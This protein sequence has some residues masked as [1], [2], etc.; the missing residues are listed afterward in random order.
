[1]FTNWPFNH[2]SSKGK[3]ISYYPS[4]IFN[5]EFDAN[6]VFEL[7]LDFPTIVAAYDEVKDVLSGEFFEGYQVSESGIGLQSFCP[8]WNGDMRWI[9]PGDEAGFAFFDKYFDKLRVAEKTNELF[10]VCNELIMY[11]GFFVVRSFTK[12][13]YYHIDYSGSVGLNAFT[14]MT[15]VMQTRV[16]NLLYHDIK[17]EEQVYNYTRGKAV[18]F[19]GDFY[20]STEPFE[21]PEPYVFLCFTYGVTDTEIWDSIAET[22]A[23]QCKIFRHP[24]QGIVYRDS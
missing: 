11:S 19:G 7:N 23:E 5:D 10:G 14:L 24:T 12:N 1:M 15:P 20:H 2:Y 6:N 3:T 21:S 18:C 22:A 4:E 9:S 8:G 17:G 16:G 13:T